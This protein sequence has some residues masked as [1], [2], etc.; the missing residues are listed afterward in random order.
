MDYVDFKRDLLIRSLERFGDQYEIKYKKYRKVNEEVE[1]LG[2]RGK[3]QPGERRVEALIDPYGLY[4]FF[5][6]ADCTGWDMVLEEINSAI[7]RNDLQNEMPTKGFVE[8][9]VV[10]QLIQIQ[11]NEELLENCPYK[12]WLNLAYVMRVVWNYGPGI[13]SILVNHGLITALNLNPKDLF[14]MAEVNITSK[15]GLPTFFNLEN[16]LRSQVKGAYNLQDIDSGLYVLST[17]KGQYGAS[18][19]GNARLMKSIQRKLGA[20]F[21]ILPSSTHEVLI[22]PEL[23][24]YPVDVVELQKLVRYMNH[25]SGCIPKEDFLSDSVY[26]FDGDK[27]KIVE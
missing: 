20:N 7:V 22:L 27:V 18:L 25:L 3:N 21:Y 13:A 11:G 19:M 1:R 14:R 15:F 8:K 24:D 9:N 16:Y 6:Q 10:I 4:T 17:D 26:E 5:L 2:F 12:S 23:E